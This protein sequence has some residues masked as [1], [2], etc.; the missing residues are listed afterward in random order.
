MK[1]SLCYNVSS[2]SEPREMTITVEIP[3]RAHEEAKP[4]IQ[5]LVRMSFEAAAGNRNSAEVEAQKRCCKEKIACQSD[6]EAIKKNLTDALNS[7]A[8]HLENA[9]REFEG[10][11][12]I[13]N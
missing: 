10:R 8:N 12:T 9:V 11:S 4:E 2:Y 1:V 7:L 6:F 3:T 5:K 13:V